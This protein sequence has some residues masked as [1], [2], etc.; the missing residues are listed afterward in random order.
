MSTSLKAVQNNTAPSYSI[1]C[2]RDDGTVIDLTAA[3]VTLLLYRGS[4]Q[5]NTGSGHTACSVLS[6]ATNGVI[7][8]TPQTGDLPTPGTYK[9]DVVVT[10]SG[11]GVET[12][13]NNVII[14]VRKLL[15]S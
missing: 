8:W 11:G 9:G 7:S 4:T 6:P 2:E 15:G 5:T 12:L 1:T 3:T 13:Y 14:K 10:Y